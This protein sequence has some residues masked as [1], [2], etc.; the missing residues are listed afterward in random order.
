MTKENV[1]GCTVKVSGQR[2]LLEEIV[3]ILE[4][5]CEIVASSEIIYHPEDDG[6]HRF[7][8]VTEVTKDE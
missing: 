5:A 8:T 3:K 1:R 4:Q 7:F 2:D 6:C